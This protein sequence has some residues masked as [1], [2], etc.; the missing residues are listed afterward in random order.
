MDLSIEKKLKA[1][2]ALQEIDSKHDQLNAMKG[3]LPMEV[4]DLE[5]ELAGLETRIEKINSEIKSCDEDIVSYKNKIKQ[6]EQYI[7]KFKQQL[8]EV[9]NNREYEALNKEI[10]IM[11]LEIQASEK[12]I[13]EYKRTIEEKQGLLKST[14]EELENRKKDLEFKKEELVAIVKETEEEEA[15]LLAER[16]K[17][18]SQIE[19]RLIVAYNRVRTN[20]KNGIAV[21]SILRGSCGGCFAKIPPQRQSDIKQ[22]FKIIDCEHCGRILVDATI[23]G[24]QSEIIPVEE[25]PKR[26]IVRAKAKA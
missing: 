12:R 23:T 11:G 14:Q 22:H 25:K 15:V 5:D 26:R 18:E 17:C 10:E 19:P 4:S 8:N 9:K 24:I 7:A 3:E 1:L 16:A 13:N 20:T 21:A 6:S 2:Y